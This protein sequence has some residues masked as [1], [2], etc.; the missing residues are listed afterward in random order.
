MPE[1]LNLPAANCECCGG[2]EF[3]YAAS[4]RGWKIFRCCSCGLF[5]VAPQPDD[6]RLS[7]I[8]GKSSGYFATA[9]KDLAKTSRDVAMN[10]HE[11]LLKNGATVGRFLDIGCSTGQLIYH[12]SRQGWIVT[13][14]DIDADA[15]AVGLN[16]GLNVSVC[17]LEDSSFDERS[18]DVI[19]MGDLIEHVRSPR[20]LLETANSFLCEG[21][22]VVI[23]TP[24]G[25]GGFARASLALARLCKFPWAHSEAPYH[26]YEFGVSSLSI[27]LSR[28][29]FE[30]QEIIYSTGPSFSYIV[31]GSGYF[32]ELKA[33]MKKSGKYRLTL[34]FFKHIPKLSFVA[35]LLL[36]LY[37]FGKIW[38]CVSDEGQRL[39]IVARK[40]KIKSIKNR[41]AE[42]A[43]C[44][45]AETAG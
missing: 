37:L 44:C 11:L 31:G 33:S 41:V 2:H 19:H 1:I 38:D 45:Q 39:T 36:P 35:A 6:Q 26:L 9:E 4:K 27:L 20:L 34:G 7:E 24:N 3:K 13:G 15:I 42:N 16:N 25:A 12:L 28:T 8:Y 5:F 14:I 22:L 43:S 23:K 32:D 29:G 30:V 18:F 21:G 40:S 17:R 10:S